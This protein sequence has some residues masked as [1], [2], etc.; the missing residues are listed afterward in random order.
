MTETRTCPRCGRENPEGMQ[1]CGQCGADLNRPDAVNVHSEERTIVGVPP[2]L[3]LL[4]L[5]AV[6]V[7]VALWGLFAGHVILGFVLLLGGLLLLRNFPEVARGHH[8]GEGTRQ[9]VR[10]FDG[11]R[12]RAGAAVEAI[13]V[14]VSAR[15]RAFELERELDQIRGSRKETLQR[16]GEAAYARDEAEVERLRGEVATAD[17]AIESKEAERE[18]VQEDAERSVENVRQSAAPTERVSREEARATPDP[19][20]T[21]TRVAT[22]AEESP[23]DEAPAG[24]PADAD[25]P[26]E[27]P[28]RDS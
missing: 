22:P 28:E 1:Y 9:A 3:A 21:D 14:K 24:A 15:K 17:R 10:T 2:A 12:D 6:L 23:A 20:I 27:H 25:A 7:G 26:A 4:F 19:A 16:L 5:G 18:R 11:A 8:Q 13:T